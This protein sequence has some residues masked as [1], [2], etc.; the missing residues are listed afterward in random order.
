MTWENKESL[1]ITEHDSCSGF[2]NQNFVFYVFY[3]NTNNLYISCVSH[4]WLKNHVGL[5]VG[6]LRIDWLSLVS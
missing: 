2:V 6:C 5:V 4:R 1:K 3:M